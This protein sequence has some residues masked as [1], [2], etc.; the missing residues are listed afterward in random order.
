MDTTRVTRQHIAS[1]RHIRVARG[2]VAVALAVTATWSGV[3]VSTAATPSNLPIEPVGYN[4]VDGKLDTNNPIANA[5]IQ[6]DPGFSSTPPSGQ[7]NAQSPLIPQAQNLVGAA[8][9]PEGAAPNVVIG[10]DD[11]KEIT[12]TKQASSKWVG[13]LHA[14]TQS[15][16]SSYCTASLI[17][18]DT[19]I[20]AGHCVAK[21]QS[22]WT[23]AAGENKGQQP[24]G[25]AAAKQIWYDKKYGENGHDWAVIKLDSAVGEKT[26][27]FGMN[28]PDTQKLVDQYA[29]VIG[30]P[31]DKD[32]DTQWADRNKVMKVTDR[33]VVYQT[34]TFNGQSGSS[35]VNDTSTIFAI[36][37]GGKTGEN[38]G[39]ILTGELF[40][41]CANVAA[42]SPAR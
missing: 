4:V 19:V 38:Y 11:R 33:Q 41:V 9:F 18:K 29:T 12:D 37:T 1:K 6:K 27:W 22:K 23:F 13:K 32:G 28:V 42:A 31:G 40:N 36:H 3:G 5:E 2:V 10:N 20:T 8:N 21:G 14:T 15:G 25:T 16:G 39:T 24:Y 7:P 17:S 26:G 34:D 35:V 30:Y